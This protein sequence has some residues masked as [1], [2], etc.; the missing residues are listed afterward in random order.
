MRAHLWTLEDARKER[1]S[2]RDYLTLYGV[3][4]AAFVALVAVDVELGDSVGNLLTATALAST[5]LFGLVLQLYGRA[6]A[7]ADEAPPPGPETSRYA[8]LM[9]ELTANTAYAAI[10]ATFVTVGLV[11]YNIDIGLGKAVNLEVAR[12]LMGAALLA[13]LLHLL[14][15]LTLVLRRTFLVTQERLT[16]ARTGAEKHGKERLRRVE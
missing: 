9:E 1:V 13:A 11:A 8:T 14:L 16:V 15:T 10:A 4:C 12:R 5:L 3:P 7:W 2:L 6:T